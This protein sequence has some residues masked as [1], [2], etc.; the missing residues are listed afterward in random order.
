VE[1]RKAIINGVAGLLAKAGIPSFR[2]AV[3]GAVGADRRVYPDQEGDRLRTFHAQAHH[4]RQL[5]DMTIQPQ[6]EEILRRVADEF[7]GLA[8]NIA[9]AAET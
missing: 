2:G 1:Y 3:C 4:A 9:A 7:D 6:V 5:A 8:H